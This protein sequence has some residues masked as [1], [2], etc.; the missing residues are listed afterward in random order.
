MND[1]ID[2][3]AALPPLRQL[4]DQTDLNARKSLGQNFIFDLNLTQRIARAAA[5][6]DGPVFEIGPGPGGLTRAL[7]LQGAKQVIAIEKDRRVIAFL[8]HLVAATQGN[9]TLVEAD[10][11]HHPIWQTAEGP[12]KIVANLPYNIATALL[13]TW[14][15]HIDAFASMTLMFQREV[16]LRLVASPGDKAY[17]RLSVITQWLCETELK[18][19]VPPQ[20]FVPAPKVTSSVVHL[21]PRTQP[22]YACAKQ[23]LEAV[24]AIAF[25]QRR[26][27]LRASFKKYGGESLLNNVDID[28]SA[29]PQD[30]S[31]EQ[32]CRLASSMRERDLLT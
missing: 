28:P 1:V 10:A 23:D 5:P 25:G 20:A 9:L 26:K 3:V 13:M 27:M 16:A 14:L 7:F 32:F 31:I 18:F 2:K 12:R 29:R 21:V 4:V 17:G 22:L 6:F 19:D 24:T 15:D 11:L 8:D 30:L